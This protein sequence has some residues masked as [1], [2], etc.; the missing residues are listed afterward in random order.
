M[1]AKIQ[2][3]KLQVSLFEIFDQLSGDNCLELIDFLS[4]QDAVIINVVDQIVRG[5][6]GLGSSGAEGFRGVDDLTPLEAARRCIAKSASEVARQEIERLER[7]LRWEKKARARDSKWARQ[8]YH[9]WPEHAWRSR[10]QRK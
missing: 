9:S 1:E 7:A 5:S 2:N 8:L 3:N 4:C 10:P 6:T